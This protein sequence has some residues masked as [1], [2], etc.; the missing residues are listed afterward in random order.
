MNLKSKIYKIK[1]SS[2]V[3]KV[4]ELQSKETQEVVTQPVEAKNVSYLKRNPLTFSIFQE[5]KLQTA[6][7]FWYYKRPLKEQKSSHVDYS[8]LQD[9]S[10]S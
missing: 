2:F 9:G 3:E 1:M 7:E 4:S 10:S 8:K 6:W 5:H